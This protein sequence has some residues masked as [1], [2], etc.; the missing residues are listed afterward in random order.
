MLNTRNEILD[1]LET[2]NKNRM[3]ANNSTYSIIEDDIGLYVDS[4]LQ[5]DV[6]QSGLNELPVRFGTVVDGFHIK[7]NNLTT[8]KNFPRRIKNGTLCATG[9][10]ISTLEYY[11]SY[12]TSAYLDNNNIQKI[13][14][15]D[16]TYKHTL[17]LRYN[18]IVDLSQDVVD[19]ILNKDYLRSRSGGCSVKLQEQIHILIDDETITRVER[20][21]KLNQFIG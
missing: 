1:W 16:S 3:Y 20:Q 14:K 9:N 21:A 12:A 13:G 8:M 10:K 2:F 4:L 18:P 17:N 19:K 11:P 6:S 7:G 5:I 15:L